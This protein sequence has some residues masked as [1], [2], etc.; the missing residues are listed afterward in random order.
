M[1]VPATPA[2]TIA[3]TN[4]ANSRI[5]ESTKKPPSR[6]S[7]PNSTRKFAACSPGA[8]Y[9]KATVDTSSG[10]QH[11]FIAN[12]NCPTN[13]L[14]YGYG[15]RIADASVLPVRIIMFPTSSST[16]LVGRN[17]RSAT[18]LIKLALSSPRRPSIA[19]GRL[20]W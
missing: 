18:V 1:A 2:S 19:I 11:S 16:F 15:G 3:S 5:D 4:G 9:P 17:V 14:P 10:N 8:P 12:R 7:A 13:S 6:S 20:R